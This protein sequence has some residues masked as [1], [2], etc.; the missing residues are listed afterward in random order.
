MIKFSRLQSIA[1]WFHI[2]MWVVAGAAI[3]V[4][5]AYNTGMKQETISN[6][7]ASTLMITL[8]LMDVRQLS[9]IRVSEL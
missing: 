7:K 1:L 3:V 8:P 2:P 9:S 5:G 6:A 4:I